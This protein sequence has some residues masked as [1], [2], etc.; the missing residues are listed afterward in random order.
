MSDPDTVQK[1]FTDNQTG[2]VIHVRTRTGTGDAGTGADAG[3]GTGDATRAATGSDQGMNTY[4]SIPVDPSN[5]LRLNQLLNMPTPENWHD[6]VMLASRID[7]L[8]HAACDAAESMVEVLVRLRDE[9]ARDVH[10]H[11]H[12]CVLLATDAMVSLHR[13]LVSYQRDT[14]LFD[15]EAVAREAVIRGHGVGVAALVLR[16][17]AELRILITREMQA[18][19]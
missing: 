17:L 18:L 10:L 13:A 11:E 4:V 12:G 14:L 5:E 19:P 9:R 7:K 16:A 3:T 2:S 15:G 1:P 8:K 6:P